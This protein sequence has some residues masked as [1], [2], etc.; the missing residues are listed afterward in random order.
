MEKK[1]VNARVKY[2]ENHITVN[3]KALPEL[4]MEEDAITG[5][6]FPWEALRSNEKE[7]KRALMIPQ[8]VNRIEND[9]FRGWY[10]VE[11]VRFD[12]KPIHLGTGV[13]ADCRALR[14]AALAEGTK[15]IPMDSFSGCHKLRQVNLPDSVTRI[16]RCG[17]KNCTALEE[18]VLPRSL[19]ILEDAAFW[20]CRALGK[21]RLPEGTKTLGEDAFGSCTSLRQV[22]L[23]ESLETIGS[24]AF[25]NCTR[26]EEIIL[27]PGIKTL[28]A[29]VFA[30]CR[31]LR[32]VVLPDSLETVSNYV[33]Y[34]CENLEEVE[35][36]EVEKFAK[37]LTG[38]PFLRKAKPWEPAGKQLPMALLNNFAG[39]ISGIQ[40]CAMG[41]H[42][43]DIDRDYRFFLTENRNIIEVC[44]RYS[45]PT[46]PEGYAN[47]RILMTPDL[48]PIAS[49]LEKMRFL[50]MEWEDK[51]DD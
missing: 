49:S 31:N 36:P 28:P 15:V 13:F 14:T 22:F 40:L 16:S 21:I 17:F 24:C 32:R 38:T 44:C 10:G 9:A 35:H 37:G 1:T 39:E 25:Q 47:E 27:P 4:I 5:F 2:E 43:F 29:G 19:E 34:G 11:H 33:F 42:W 7:T 45:D 26:L 46:K 41:Y 6:E 18:V 8:H 12:R 3:L 51:F 50:D 20:G 48:E 30:G 23:P